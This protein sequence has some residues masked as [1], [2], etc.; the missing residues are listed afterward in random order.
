MAKEL[1]YP[2]EARNLRETGTALVGIE[3]D[4]SGNL[5]QL[6]WA[7]PGEIHRSL[8]KEAIRVLEKINLDFE[9]AI[10]F[11]GNPTKAYFTIPIR[12]SLS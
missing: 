10:D 6:Y 1:H 5:I 7:N 4:E 3:V 9:S 2:Q 8:I 11:Q 12:F